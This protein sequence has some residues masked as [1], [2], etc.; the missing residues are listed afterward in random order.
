MYIGLHV[1]YR[2]LLSDFIETW[3]FIER[4]S[5]NTQKSNFMKIL[6]IRAGLF[7][8]ERR[9]TDMMQLIVAFRKFSNAPKNGIFMTMPELMSDL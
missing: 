1:K 9:V 7:H 6:P 2:L 3:T 5:K 8:A 4:F